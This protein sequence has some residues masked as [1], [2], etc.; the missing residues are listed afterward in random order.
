M[1]SGLFEFINQINLLLF[2]VLKCTMLMNIDYARLSCRMRPR[3]VEFISNDPSN[4]H[5]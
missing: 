1:T 5:C 3:F 2:A 4:G